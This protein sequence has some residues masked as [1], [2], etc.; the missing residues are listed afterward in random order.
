MSHQQICFFSN[1][2]PVQLNL[3]GR[4]LESPVLRVSWFWQEMLEGRFGFGLTRLQ[5]LSSSLNLL[6]PQVSL[7]YE[8]VV[9]LPKMK[10]AGR[11]VSSLSCK[12]NTHLCTVGWSHSLPFPHL[13]KCA[14]SCQDPSCNLHLSPLTPFV[15]SSERSGVC[16]RR[17]HRMSIRSIGK[18]LSLQG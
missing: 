18:D 11:M 4:H 12:F 13:L 16:R 8:V 7:Q 10:G 1:I 14:H 2:L 3:L 5:V 17:S 15:S 6:V 9:Q